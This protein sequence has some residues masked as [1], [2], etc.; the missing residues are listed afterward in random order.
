MESKILKIIVNAFKFIIKN[1]PCR[2]SINIVAVI[3]DFVELSLETKKR[4]RTKK[5]RQRG[6]Q[7]NEKVIQN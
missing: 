2:Y 4:M 6:I 7:T 1:H 5:Q 3:G